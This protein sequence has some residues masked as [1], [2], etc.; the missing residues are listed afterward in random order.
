MAF[1]YFNAIFLTH[2][3]TKRCSPLVF[4][5]RFKKMKDLKVVKNEALDI[6]KPTITSK[7]IVLVK[8][9]DN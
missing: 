5:Q 6:P 3:I 8:C 2:T 7:I 9:Y 4:A 1:C